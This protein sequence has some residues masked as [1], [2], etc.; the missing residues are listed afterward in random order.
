MT[1]IEHQVIAYADSRELS[2]VRHLVH[3]VHD[4]ISLKGELG[5]PLLP[6]TRAAIDDLEAMIVDLKLALLRMHHPDQLQLPLE[7]PDAKEG[8]DDDAASC[9]A[10]VDVLGS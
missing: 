1:D 6:E 4:A 7:D 8:E 9:P 2:V 5:L 3:A 10:L